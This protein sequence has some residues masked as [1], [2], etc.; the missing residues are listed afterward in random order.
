MNLEKAEELAR[1]AHDNQVR[2][3]GTPYIRHPERIVDQIEKI[4]SVD[5]ILFSD[6]NVD[7][8]IQAAWLHDSMEDS[9]VNEKTLKNHKFHKDVIDAVVAL[10]HDRKLHKSY[11]EYIEG[12][13]QNKIARIVKIFD[14]V[15]NLSGDPSTRQIEKYS[16]AMLRL[17][18][19]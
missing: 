1:A 13:A 4:F 18:K 15:D 14:I 12:V 16:L 3:D 2:R 11:M 5:S 17:N 7:H 19:G 10:T 8:L 9:W 6:V